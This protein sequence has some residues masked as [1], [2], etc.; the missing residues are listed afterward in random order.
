MGTLNLRF[1]LTKT[2]KK[3]ELK[4]EPPGQRKRQKCV[5]NSVILKTNHFG[6]IL[7][8]FS[9]LD[10]RI[11]ISSFLLAKLDQMSNLEYPHGYFWKHFFFDFIKG[12]PNL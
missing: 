7:D 3:T 12:G 5:G 2:T 9:A 6:H 8:V 1:D 11:L 10:A 4:S